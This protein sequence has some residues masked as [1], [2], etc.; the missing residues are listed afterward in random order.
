MNYIKSFQNTHT[1][2]ASMG[3]SYSEDELMHILLDNFHEGGKYSAQI[4]SHQAELIRKE[5]VT[6]Q[7][8]LAISSLQTDDLNLDSS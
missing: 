3:N 8:Y 1:L 4:S 7:K 2:S 5:K 6:D